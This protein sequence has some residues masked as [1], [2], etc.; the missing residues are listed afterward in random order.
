MKVFVEG[1]MCMHCVAHV[2]AALEKIDGVKESK[3]T[4]ETGLA[5]LTLSKEVSDEQIKTAISD[6]G[7]KVINIER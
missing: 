3:V 6:S 2:K 5:E 1:M 7:Y 4:L